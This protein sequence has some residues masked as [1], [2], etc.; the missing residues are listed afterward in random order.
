[1]DLNRLVVPILLSIVLLL[2]PSYVYVGQGQTITTTT[3][4]QCIDFNQDKVCEFI[5][6]ANG[7]VMK[8]PI[9]SEQPTTETTSKKPQTT[10]FLSYRNPALGITIQYPVGWQLEE[11]ENKIT[12][13]QQKDIVSLETNI[14]NN[15]DTSLSEYVN[16]RLKELREQRQDFNLI[17]STPTTISGNP[18][19]KVAYTFVKEDGPRAGEINK[20]FRIW[21]INNNKLYTIAYVAEEDRFSEYLPKVEKTIDS[22]RINT[23]TIPASTR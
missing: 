6:L 8:N 4:H 22:F 13:V 17:E 12:F 9:V 16:T 21:S 23:L 19:H 2:I 20:V 11:D 18:A 15:I 14:E 5:L 1:M 10:G 7:T 3:T